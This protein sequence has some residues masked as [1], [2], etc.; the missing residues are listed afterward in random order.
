MLTKRNIF[1]LLLVGF[2]CIFIAYIN[3]IQ[4]DFS[5]TSKQESLAVVTPIVTQ[6]STKVVPREPDYE[7]VRIP[8]F[9]DTLDEFFTSTFRFHNARSV[10]DSI[11]GWDFA[12]DTSYRIVITAGIADTVSWIL[13]T[14]RSAKPDSLDFPG[15]RVHIDTDTMPGFFVALREYPKVA[16]KFAANPIVDYEFKVFKYLERDSLWTTDTSSL[17]SVYLLQKLAR[18]K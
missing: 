13:Y 10:Y 12:D 8:T 5:Q 3:S 15:T 17:R 14:V 7:E 11:T 2:L 16:Q 9:T 1:A 4:G 18:K 6:K